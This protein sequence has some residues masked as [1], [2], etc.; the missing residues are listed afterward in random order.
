MSLLQEIQESVVQEGSHLGSILLKLRLLAARLGSDILK[1]WVKHESEGYP[2]DAEVPSYR[3][4]ELTYRGLFSDPFGSTIRDRQIPLPL[5][6]KYA[7][8]C[9]TKHEV[10]VSIAAIDEMLKGQE[11]GG[12]KP[13]CI[14]AANL[15]P[16]LQGK[17]YE[18]HAC[19]GVSGLI[20]P[21]EL[22]EIQQIVRSR[23]LE[24]TFEL[25]K[26]VPGAMQ[27]AFSK[28]I[29]NKKETEQAQ[30]ISQQIIYGNVSTAVAGGPGANIAVAITE[31]DSS[32]FIKHLVEK[33]IPEADAS[34]LAKIMESEEPTSSDEPFGEKAKSW[35]AA[36]LKKAGKGIWSVGI[37]VATKMLT[38]AALKYYGIK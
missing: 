24:L 29:E 6:K 1:E 16:L 20:S 21:T 35:I 26:S 4:L 17:I 31:R 32:S 7:G 12:S 14:D 18:S 15:I 9:W 13:F 27:V 3:I 36:N 37:P 10:T 11:S 23:I 28:P 25:E 2:R 5:I 22:Y 34:E 19:N 33:G 38:E 30:H 8:E